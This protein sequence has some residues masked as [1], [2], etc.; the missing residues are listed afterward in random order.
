MIRR[1]KQKPRVP[2]VY[3]DDL[4]QISLP[5]WMQREREHVLVKQNGTSYTRYERCVILLTLFFLVIVFKDFQFLMLIIY[6]STWY[7][8][9]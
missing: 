4:P 2:L 7:I 3:C 1:K 9:L 6:I 8:V 5:E